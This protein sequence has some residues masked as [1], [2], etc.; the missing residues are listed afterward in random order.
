VGCRAAVGWTSKL[1]KAE[2]Q[3]PRP[4][5]WF[6]MSVVTGN[7]VQS[8]GLVLAA[9]L[10]WVAASW[11]AAAVLRVV[12]ML[13]GWFLVYICSH[14]IAHWVA[15]RAVRIRFDGYGLRGTDQPEVYP[16]GI[17]QVMRV[18][19]FF[20]ALT[21]K[22]SMQQAGAV[23]KAI[24][25]SAGETSTT[26]CTLLAA[27]YAWVSGIPGGDVLFI[28][29]VCWDIGATITTARTPRGDYAKAMRVLRMAPTGRAMSG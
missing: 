8:A 18:L 16:P 2:T 24:M 27:G 12:P 22:A 11:H 9:G 14:A 6:R 4:K 15:G 17:H 29:T 1:K 25:F 20:S 3:Q 13:M 23:A 26:L 21:E 28:F 7:L 19:P 5:L 10:L